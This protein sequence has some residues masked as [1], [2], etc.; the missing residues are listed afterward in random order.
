MKGCR[1]QDYDTLKENPGGRDLRIKLLIKKVK[2]R[3]KR[4]S[5]EQA[6]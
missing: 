6:R 3:I 1:R 4:S 2:R 5:E